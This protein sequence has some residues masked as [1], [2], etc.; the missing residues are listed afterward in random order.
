MA[1]KL[2]LEV[3]VDNTGG[4]KA[5]QVVNQEI[6]RTKSAAQGIDGSN[7]DKFGDNVKNFLQNPL[8]AAGDSAKNFLA[9]IGPIGAGIAGV[10]VALTAFAAAGYESAKSLGNLGDQVGDTAVRMGL[11]VKEVEQFNFALK[12]AGSEGIS[13][14]EP[15]MRRLSQALD[16]GSS[17]GAKAR[18]TLRD[19][20]IS[21]RDVSGNLRPMSQLFVEISERLNGISDTAQR[22]AKAI[23]ILGR[24]GLEVLPDLLELSST[25]K[26]VQGIGDKGILSQAD[27]DRFGVY[28]KQIAEVDQQWR[29]LSIRLK[30]PIAATVLVS[31]KFLSGISTN[32]GGPQAGPQ[33]LGTI[34]GRIQDD[35][36]AQINAS[37]RQAPT[38]ANIPTVV[39]TVNKQIQ[40]NLAAS[41][42]LDRFVSGTLEGAQSELARLKQKYDDARVSAEGLGKSGSVLPQVAAD[43]RKQVEQTRDAY[44]RQNEIVKS[45]SE[46]EAKRFAILAQIRQITR[47]NLPENRGFLRIGPGSATES[48]LTQQDVNAANLPGRSVPSLFGRRGAFPGQALQDSNRDLTEGLISS[49]TFVSPEASRVASTGTAEQLKA[50]GEGI[51]KRQQDGDAQHLDSLKAETDA[52][53]RI[54]EI[55][56]GPGGELATANQ[57]AAVRQSAIDQEFKLT[58]DITKMR[59]DSLQNEIDLRLRIADIEKQRLD[60]T[61]NQI[62]QILHTG[63][64]DPSRFASQLG[65]TIRGAALKPIEQGLSNT[66]AKAIQ[67]TLFGA[68][69]TGGLNGL[70]GG[71]FGSKGDPIKVATDA[72][73]TATIANTR[74]IAALSGAVGGGPS[75]SGIVPGGGFIDAI[76]GRFGGG[77]T[78]NP[79]V[80]NQ[81]PNLTGGITDQLGLPSSVGSFSLPTASRSG[82][83]LSQLSGFS[84]PLGGLDRS[85]KIP[86]LPTTTLSAALGGGLESAG[87]LVE[88]LSGTRTSGARGALQ[89]A[90]GAA[91]L[92]SGILPLISKSL[93]AAGPIGALVGAG[94]GLI[95]SF[96]PDPKVGR[97]NAIDSEIAAA[98]YTLPQSQSYLLDK[99]GRN[100]DYDLSGSP[101]V[102]QNYYN[103]INAI[104]TQSFEQAVKKNGNVFGDV[105]AKQLS[106]HAPLRNAVQ[107]A[108]V[109]G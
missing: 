10:G 94:L 35:V 100:L 17:E 66:I 50:L 48:I 80:F 26:T 102:V 36:L 57:V 5:L 60:A 81:F 12:L 54:L 9:S 49:S 15:S 32:T 52:T 69:G 41:K 58:G 97:A 21:T 8:A 20:G 92:I 51:I 70:L 95:S 30:E 19:L 34:T 29:L 46:L 31:L 39:S 101:R 82:F 7:L 79:F 37:A 77:A 99:S 83:S 88:L 28:Q 3:V 55:R 103:N 13:T 4:I 106:T 90:G 42:S 53:I 75:L 2:Q 43:H 14:L 1:S 89:V 78:S 11:T 63:I 96:L 104:D 40:D 85:L 33:S 84:F 91:G 22:N 65:T 86:G 71:L 61:R 16:E 45:L 23:Q 87:G 6:Q 25:L 108:A 76:N 74:A 44:E 105:V 93:G 62:E 56:T 109:N 64:T 47:E 72:N 73:T 38:A 27:I 98:R 107:H 59:Q 67:P 68:D 18:D 24:S